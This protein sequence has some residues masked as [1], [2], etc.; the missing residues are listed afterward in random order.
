[1]YTAASR[2][3]I[4][5]F[6]IPVVPQS[7]QKRQS[8]FFQPNVAL[9]FFAPWRP[10][11]ESGFESEFR[12]RRYTSEAKLEITHI[13]ARASDL[14]KAGAGGDVGIG[15]IPVRMVREVE[16]L[17]TELQLVPLGEG[18]SPYASRKSSPMMPGVSIVLR[19]HVAER[20]RKGGL[21][22]GSI[23][24][25]LRILLTAPA[26]P[27]FS[28]VESG[29][30]NRPPCVGGVETVGNRH[31]KPGLQGQNAAQLPPARPLR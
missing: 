21:K 12:L 20:A 14:P 5:R 17:E 11:R 22:R 2:S 24:E 8:T 10:L 9:F 19:P 16:R 25:P 23:E 15:I 4:R 28:P 26:E 30:S 1:M 18:E 7:T 27:H 6:R 31:R 29:R 3:T 13:G